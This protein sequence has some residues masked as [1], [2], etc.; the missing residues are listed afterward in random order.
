MPVTGPDFIVGEGEG[1][2]LPGAFDVLVKVRS[3]HTG[4]V[5]AVLEETVPP[6]TLI[7]PHVHDN[8]V[9]VY[10]LSGTVG[11][12]VGD[13]IRTAEQGSWALKPRSVVHAM[14]NADTQPARIMEVLTPAGTERW[15][16]EVASLAVGDDD[17]FGAAC[18]RHGIRF[19]TDSPWTDVLR[20]RVGL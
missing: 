14:W 6:H 19:L 5:M 3:E 17:G 8:D 18:Q 7:P 15:F 11:V 1:T 2:R 10:V 20:A 9:W 13:E 4:G 16:E 12:L